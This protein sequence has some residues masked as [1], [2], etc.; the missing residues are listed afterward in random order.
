MDKEVRGETFANRQR[1]RTKMNV[2]R[3]MEG[4]PN[5]I[6]YIPQF[7][8]GERMMNVEGESQGGYNIQIR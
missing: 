2:N 8:W 4:L 1:N 5:G 6:Y 3:L 7:C